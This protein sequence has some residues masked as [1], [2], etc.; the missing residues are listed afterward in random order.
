VGTKKSLN[1]YKK[2]I[3]NDVHYIKVVPLEKMCSQLLSL[4]CYVIYGVATVNLYV[5]MYRFQSMYMPQKRYAIL[6]VLHL[7]A[8]GIVLGFDVMSDCNIVF[9]KWGA[10]VFALWLMLSTGETCMYSV[11]LCVKED[12]ETLPTSIK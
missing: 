1:R 8:V 12:E 5:Y 10:I 9:A 3:T 2:L 11:S 6:S 7:L 4:A